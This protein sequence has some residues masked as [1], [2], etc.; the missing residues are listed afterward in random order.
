MKES[1]RSEL[2]EN[3]LLKYRFATIPSP[4]QV[5]TYS[6][7]SALIDVSVLSGEKKIYSNSIILHVP[8][9][10]DATDLTENTPTVTP[11]TPK[12]AVGPASII[13]GDEIGLDPK[14]SYAGFS[15]TCKAEA[16]YL[17][18]YDLVFT[19]NVSEVNLNTGEFDIP[20]LEISG[21]TSDPK[22]FQKRI[23]TYHLEKTLPQFYLKN[24]VSTKKSAT[25]DTNVPCGQFSNSE[26]IRLAWESNGTNFKVITSPDNKPIYDGPDTSVEL[27]NGMTD[28]TTFM[29]IASVTGGEES[30]T[31]QPGYETV[32]L[33]DAVTVKITN[34]DLTPDSVAVAKDME[35]GGNQTVAGTS[36][37]HATTIKGALTVDG[38]TALVGSLVAN[39]GL[40]SMMGSA[41]SVKQ[42]SFVAKTDGFVVGSV[43]YPSSAGLKSSAVI[44][45]STD[46]VYYWATGGNQV[47]YMAKG[48]KSCTSWITPDSFTM[49]VRKGKSWSTKIWY[50]DGNKE[51]PGVSFFWIPLGSD[52]GNTFE[53]VSESDADEL[54]IKI[55]KPV[56]HS[57]NVNAENAVEELVKVVEELFGKDTMLKSKDKF[58]K[59]LLNL[60]CRE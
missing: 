15:C 24:F 21:E 7:N 52:T 44:Y 23:N 14:K 17:I 39:T 20:I 38:A 6:A 41:Q 33:Y 37:L 32:C 42:G 18:N 59:A 13:K 34:P 30:G 56:Q 50:C 43:T 2:T 26:P 54:Q 47:Y 9:G 4:I 10:P 5:S 57:T 58:K 19:I 16:D 12:W 53:K 51:N 29:L 1:K 28:T 46:G 25:S 35:V 22:A 48:M 27:P 31:P 8:I 3:C 55:P 36:A 60:V 49:P 45:G 11:N 40:V